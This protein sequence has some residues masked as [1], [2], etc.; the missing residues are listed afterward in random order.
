MSDSHAKTEFPSRLRLAQ[1]I[2]DL[3]V[4]PGAA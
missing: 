4:P 2:A 3:L 1:G